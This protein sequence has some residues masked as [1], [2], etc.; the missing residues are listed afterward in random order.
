MEK[1]TVKAY[2]YYDKNGKWSI[3]VSDDE[4]S[5]MSMFLEDNNISEEDITKTEEL[6]PYRKIRNVYTGKQTFISDAI[7]NIKFFPRC[8]LESDDFN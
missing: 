1:K 6:E 5:A 4:Y 2:K 3:I 7:R 8:I